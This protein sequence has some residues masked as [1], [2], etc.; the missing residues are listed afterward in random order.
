MFPWR[1]GSHTLSWQGASWGHSLLGWSY[2]WEWGHTNYSANHSTKNNYLHPRS[3]NEDEGLRPSRGLQNILSPYNKMLHDL[4][5]TRSCGEHYINHPLALDIVIQLLALAFV[6]YTVPRDS[7]KNPPQE[8]SFTLT[9]GA[10]RKMAN[11]KQPSS[12]P[13]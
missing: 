8:A 9:S 12:R 5:F 11:G 7:T 13:P 10:E 3:H 1:S 2:Q 4:W 6:S